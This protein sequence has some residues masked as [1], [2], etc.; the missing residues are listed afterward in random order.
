M[1]SIERFPS[2][3][4]HRGPSRPLALRPTR[5]PDGRPAGLPTAGSGR[6]SGSPARHRRTPVGGRSR[7]IL[8]PVALVA[9]GA[10]SVGLSAD[11]FGDAPVPTAA[12]AV[13]APL[14]G[15]TLAALRDREVDRAS[16]G[17]T[18]EV[19]D[20][21]RQRIK[22]IRVEQQVQ[23]ERERAKARER[24]RKAAIAAARA[25]RA[26]LSGY[27]IS[28]PFGEYSYIRSG[29]HTGLDLSAPEGTPVNAVAAG[30]VVSAAYDGSFG[31][32]VV[33]RHSDG[34]ETWYCHLSAIA[35][36]VGQAVGNTTQVGN[37]GSTGNVTGPHL[38]L[39]VHP[40]GGDPVD[41]MS[42]MAAHGVQL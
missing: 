13:S 16:R 7:R 27:R 11:T 15:D 22:E 25:W 12:G 26:P 35:V 38:H 42:W 20:G 14:S 29:M 24:A 5:R 34:T 37:V 19:L 23:R 32:K 21:D 39:E 41:P 4:K 18:R 30:E 10:A 31:N 1:Q 40:G 33:V 9:L 6:S 8:T 28:S 17:A 3:S 2:V 36:S